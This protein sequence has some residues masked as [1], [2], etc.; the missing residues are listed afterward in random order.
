[1]SRPHLLAYLDSDEIGGAEECL[2]SLL[3]Q[4]QEALRLS[5]AGIDADVID[6]I[7][8]R[9]PSAET[10]LLPAAPS[11]TSIN[12]GVA[13]VRAFRRLKPDIVHISLRHPYS[14]QWGTLA[15]LLTPGA[16][17]VAVEQLP[18]PPA[19]ERQ[20]SIKRMLAK[21]LDAHIAVGSDA[22]RNLEAWVKL[23]PNSIATI[24]NAR[25]SDLVP[26]SPAPGPGIA[27]VSVGRLHEQKGFDVL[28]D[29]MTRIPQLS[30]RIVGDGPERDALRARASTSGV[31]DQLEFV[32]WLNDPEPELARA[33]IFVLPSRYEGLPLS[34]IEA[35]FAELAIVA[36]DVGS[37]RELV[38]DGETGLLVP[39]DDATALADAITKLANDHDLRRR[40][41]SAA[42]ARALEHFSL[43]GMVDTYQ[44]LYERLLA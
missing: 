13:H 17:V 8:Q 29:A 32:G 18:I 25:P 40:L 27:C 23:P 36:S 22:A 31:L 30:V 34:I 9:A 33:E 3:E 5:I 37:V 15:A 43:A 39:P 19:N 35:M 2:A 4:I 24:H 38:L 1:M 21:R 16:R 14:C 41:G 42:R 10:V 20:A 11:K 12:G 6:W 26:H 44:R 28:I 7:S